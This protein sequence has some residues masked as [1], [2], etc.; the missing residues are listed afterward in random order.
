MKAKNAFY[1]SLITLGAV[2]CAG[3]NNA[4][5][6]NND[7]P[8]D[9]HE[10]VSLQLNPVE[11]GRFAGRSVALKDAQGADVEYQVTQDRC[12]VFVADVKAGQ[13]AVYNIVD[14]KPQEVKV[15]ATGKVYPNRV[16][17]IAWE[18]DKVAFRAY[19]PALQASGE[20]AFG[21]DVWVKCVSEPVVENRYN[22]ELDPAT[23]AR[24]DSLN[25][26]KLYADIEAAQKLRRE[27]S[28]HYD[29]GNGLDC[30]KVGPT[31]GG[32]A[33]AIILG[34]SIVYPYC[35]KECEI[36]DNGPL[37]FQV[38]L[39]YHTTTI[40]D[41]DITEVRTITLDAASCLNHTVVE[42]KGAP[43]NTN[44]VAGPV[45]HN[46]DGGTYVADAANGFVGYADPTDRPSE[47]YGTIYVG[48]V[49]TQPI[50]DARLVL[51]PQEEAKM[52]GADGHVLAYSTLQAGQPLDYYW[53]GAWDKVGFDSFD[54][55]KAYL[56]NFAQNL[57]QPLKVNFTHVDK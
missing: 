55:W 29:H 54:A 52:R 48:A 22:L 32:G 2:A 35:Y 38:R 27:T 34:D 8:R 14:E 57:K 12:L 15:V 13:K 16:D 17:D 26:T 42:Y 50:T 24:I 18:N 36:L 6:V 3:D 19:G 31:L 7:S 10:L 4:I 41:Q 56:D 40:A 30:Y 45:V 44:V 1:L 28:Y 23:N 46:P 25:N 39:T 5:V 49:F 20:K 33:S 51:F 37:R 53:G 21:Y 43:T 47:G 9:R 11:S